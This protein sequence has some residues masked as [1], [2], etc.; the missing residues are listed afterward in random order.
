MFLDLEANPPEGTRNYRFQNEEDPRDYQ[1][2]EE[3]DRIEYH[4]QEH[5]PEAP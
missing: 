2:N 5:P 1:Y 3:D 4:R